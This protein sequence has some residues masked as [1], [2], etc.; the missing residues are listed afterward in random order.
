MWKF[1]STSIVCEK[2]A[3]QAAPSSFF[4]LRIFAI[5]FNCPA[6]KRRGAFSACLVNIALHALIAHIHLAKPLQNIVCAVIIIVRD[7]LLNCSNFFLHRLLFGRG[8]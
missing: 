6:G 1:L 4:I 3:A 7:K 8:F 2:G 5:H